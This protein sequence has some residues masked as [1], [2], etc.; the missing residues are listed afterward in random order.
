MSVNTL[1]GIRGKSGH[2]RAR[3]RGLSLIELMIATT[4]SLVILAAV[5]WVYQGTSQTYRSHDALA[6]MQEGARYAFE[7]MSKDLRMAGV[8]GCPY[9]SVR[10]VA[11]SAA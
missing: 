6:R 10:P 7:L 8:A 3:M 9:P 2:S 1:L 11:A 4:I 5:G